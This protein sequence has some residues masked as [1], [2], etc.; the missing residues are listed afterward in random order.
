VIISNPALQKR[1]LQGKKRWG[2]D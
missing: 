1:N 2:K